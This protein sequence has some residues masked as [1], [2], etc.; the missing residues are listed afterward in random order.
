[1]IALIAIVLAG[2]PMET[3]VV[4]VTGVVA[5]GRLREPMTSSVVGGGVGGDPG[6]EQEKGL[7]GMTILSV[8]ADPSTAER[9]VIFEVELINKGN[10]KIE[11]PVNPNLGD[12]E[13]ARPGIP[14]AFTSCHITLQLQ[15]TNGHWLSGDMSLYGSKS[16]TGSVRELNPGDAL[17]VR[18]RTHLK[19]G[20]PG[21]TSSEATS[22]TRVIAV[23]LLQENF[24]GEKAGVLH[25]DSRQSAPEVRSSDSV[26]LSLT[27]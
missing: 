8:K 14:Y 15:G 6:V 16:I 10:R 26:S 25:Q 9:S 27:P 13:S 3:F 5:R 21:D 19:S 1:M 12:F 24:V 23:F 11:L 18:A 2:L 20:S 4:D 7:L 17:E 22:F